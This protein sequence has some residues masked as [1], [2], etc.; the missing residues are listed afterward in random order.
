[1]S[2]DKV[3]V[4]YVNSD[5]V[6]AIPVDTVF[7]SSDDDP[8][9]VIFLSENPKVPPVVELP[10]TGGAVADGGPF[11]S[12]PDDDV[13]R[14]Q[15]RIEGVFILNREAAQRLVDRLQD[16]LSEDHDDDE[17]AEEAE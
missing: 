2:T 7:V 12:R 10:V 9:K 3:V 15:R 13:F 11:G 6:K 16:I 8:I 14:L 4:E 1:M 5:Q 17:D